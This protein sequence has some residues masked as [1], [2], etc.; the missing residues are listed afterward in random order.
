M[1]KARWW[2]RSLAVGV[3]SSSAAACADLVPSDPSAQGPEMNGIAAN[4][5]QAG[6]HQPERLS[7]RLARQVP[8]FGGIYVD[9]NGVLSVYLT[10]L[11]SEQRMRSAVA[12][13]LRGPRGVTPIRFIR[14]EYSFRVL[15]DWL[16]SLTPHIGPTLVSTEVDERWN[17]IQ[18]GVDSEAGMAAVAEA[19][20]RA[21]VPEGAVI[22][23]IVPRPTPYVDLRNLLNPHRGGA[24][25]FYRTSYQPSGA[26]ACTG[27]WNV[28]WQGTSYMLVN[29]HCTEY[30]GGPYVGTE[31]F[32][33]R[34]PKW[35]KER[36]KY[37]VGVEV[38]DPN[39]TA[40]P[41]C[42]PS[43]ASLGC[44]YSDAALVAIQNSNRS[45]DLGGVHRTTTPVRLPQYYGTLNIDMANTHFRMSG[46]LTDLIVGDSVSKVGRTTGWSRGVITGTCANI[47][48]G[49]RGYL[50]SAMVQGP[51]GRGDSGSPVFWTNSQGQHYV[52]GMLF[53]GDPNH[54]NVVGDNYGFSK[55]EWI[56]WEL[57]VYGQHSLTVAGGPGVPGFSYE[58]GDSSGSL[59]PDPGFGCEDPTV[60]IC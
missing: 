51:A 49:N 23:R 29:S 16:E 54:D 30:F 18:I 2:L 56:S 27:G 34:V 7:E 43:S 21:R 42:S 36:W 45:A 13:V 40:L 12:P 24:Q 22:S 1:S 41:S 38:Q 39:W 58:E 4:A 59:E 8:E 3:F 32:Q 25:V 28:T 60:I 55:W 33:P 10:E 50:C 35:E 31:I 57:G 48:Y 37:Q 52:V 19:L 53:S 6:K 46:V 5:E 26:A 20:R 47:Y 15:S 9:E 44:R 14:G 11:T 17:R